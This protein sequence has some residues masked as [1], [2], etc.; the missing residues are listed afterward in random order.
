[1]KPQL[2]NTCIY[3]I[4]QCPGHRH[5]LTGGTEDI[6]PKSPEKKLSPFG[7]ARGVFHFCGVIFHAVSSARLRNTVPHYKH[8]LDKHEL[9]TRKHS[10]TSLFATR[11]TVF[12]VFSQ[13][14]DNP[15]LVQNWWKPKE[16]VRA[17]C[18]V[19]GQAWAGVVFD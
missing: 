4:E 10:K 15:A 19:S 5:R 7:K 14:I 6:P 8:F 16:G 3:F 11:N 2:S 9:D 1:M 12:R 13:I 17:S 18:K